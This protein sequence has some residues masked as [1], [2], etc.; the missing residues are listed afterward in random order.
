MQQEKIAID[1]IVL[2]SYNIENKYQEVFLC[3]RKLLL[4]S[5]SQAY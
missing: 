2:N 1:I 3:S 5:L 4:Q